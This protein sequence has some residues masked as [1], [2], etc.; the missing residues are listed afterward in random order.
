MAEMDSEDA[1]LLLLP[2]Q[3][4]SD[5]KHH[6]GRCTPSG[7]AGSGATRPARYLRSGGGENDRPPVSLGVRRL[8]PP[9]RTRPPGLLRSPPRRDALLASWQAY[10]PR[11][12]RRD[13]PAGAFPSSR[14]S[15]HSL[16]HD[17]GRDRLPQGREGE[18]LRVG[19]WGGKTAIEGRG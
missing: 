6:G 11:A 14:R 4:L 5:R 12:L 3:K 7:G 17:V 2:R 13:R 19:T 8:W 10:R 1:L 18:M 15:L 16:G 9:R